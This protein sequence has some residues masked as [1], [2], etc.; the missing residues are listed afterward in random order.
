MDFR[1]AM[2]LKTATLNHRVDLFVKFQFR[3][4]DDNQDSWHR[5]KGSM[6]VALSGKLYSLWC[7]GDH[8]QS[9][10]SCCHSTEDSFIFIYHFPILEAIKWRVYLHVIGIAVKGDLCLWKMEPKGSELQSK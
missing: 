1:L 9:L 7:L 3:V 6:S 4:K 8:D 2:F 5:H 10:L